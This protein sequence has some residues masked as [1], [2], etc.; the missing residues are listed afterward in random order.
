M[1]LQRLFGIQKPRDVRIPAEFPV[2]L[3]RK[4]TEAVLQFDATV[5]GF[6]VPKGGKP[7]FVAAEITVKGAPE[8]NLRSFFPS[9]LKE[10]SR[11][12]LSVEFPKRLGRHLS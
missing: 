7:D 9:E 12:A 6:F 8:M 11:H 4:T 5:R 2:T 1:D 3:E 10:V